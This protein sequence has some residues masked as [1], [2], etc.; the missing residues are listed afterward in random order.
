MSNSTAPVT[1]HELVHNLMLMRQELMSKLVDPKR[2]INS[3]CGYPDQITPEV[4]REMYEREGIATRVVNVMP[5]ECWQVHPEIVQQEGSEETEFEKAWKNTA[6]A[7]NL[8]AMMHRADTLSGIGHFGVILIGLDDGKTLDL[9]VDG[10]DETGKKIG[11]PQRR[12]IYV[13]AFDESCVK[14]DSY[15]TD[16]TN[17]RYGLP[18]FYSITFANENLSSRQS[19]PADLTARKIHW[20]RVIHVADGCTIDNVFGTPRM[21][22]VFNRLYDIRKTL[23]GSG[24][25]FWKG[26]FPGYSFEVN[27]EVTQD[28]D[29]DKDKLREEFFNYS[30][31]LQRYLALNGVTAKSLSPQVA[32][33]ST[34]FNTQIEAICISKGIPK[35]VFIGSEQ[36]Q[37]ASTQDT[38][39]WNGRVAGRQMSY[40]TPDL[41][42]RFV[43]RLIMVGALPSPA[44]RPQGGYEYEVVWPD[45][46]SVTPQ[47]RAEVALKQAQAL[48]SFISSQIDALIEPTDFLVYF[49]GM[50]MDEATK[51]IENARANVDRSIPDDDTETDGSQADA[52]A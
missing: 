39:R 3:E 45:L 23:G 37:L 49:L 4:Y 33:P 27:P 25:M 47:E 1:N 13:R 42:R 48:A 17:P 6:A 14:I 9:P 8:Y 32:D 28:A 52:T 15:Q 43:D 20:S 5:D 2:D 35:R 12:V 18:T 29:F 16:V 34:H 44:E 30:N 21:K 11:N 19:A 22:S 36:A 26:G 41:I 38:R 7:H 31:G 24:E 10:I 46:N 51:L 40:L 50:S